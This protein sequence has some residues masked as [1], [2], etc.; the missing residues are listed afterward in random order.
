V[1]HP[2]TLLELTVYDLDEDAGPTFTLPTGEMNLQKLDFRSVSKIYREELFNLPYTNRKTLNSLVVGSE[3]RL[4]KCYTLVHTLWLDSMSVS[5]EKLLCA[6]DPNNDAS[7]PLLQ[8]LHVISMDLME[9]TAKPTFVQFGNLRRL[10]LESCQGS[11][12]LLRGLMRDHVL[13]ST[14]STNFLNLKEFVFRHEQITET[15]CGALNQFLSSFSGLELVSILLENVDEGPEDPMA[16][17]EQH[18]PTLQVLIYEARRAPRRTLGEDTSL[19]LGDIDDPSSPISEIFSLCPKLRELS[20]PIDWDKNDV[21]GVSLHSV[22]LLPSVLLPRN[23][24]VKITS[25][26]S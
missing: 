16:F 21:F 2:S 7:Y 14:G 6:N 8:E 12:K 5:L 19:S 4:F 26:M 9:L 25:P 10:A 20:I 17:L 23:L 22:V 13:N 18:G 24:L 11:E 1:N 3:T 15:L